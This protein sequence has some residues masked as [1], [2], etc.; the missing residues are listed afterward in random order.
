[1]VS[2]FYIFHFAYKYK[3]VYLKNYDLK[4][5]H[6]ATCLFNYYRAAL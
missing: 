6:D 3:I 4:S 5:V 2:I 1:M